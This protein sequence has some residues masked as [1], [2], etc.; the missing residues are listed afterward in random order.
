MREHYDN[1]SGNNYN[2]TKPNQELPAR[3]VRNI[4]RALQI[5]HEK[6]FPKNGS[7]NWLTNG[8]D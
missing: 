5:D 2:F 1:L 6:Q 4:L 7:T 8:E 3:S